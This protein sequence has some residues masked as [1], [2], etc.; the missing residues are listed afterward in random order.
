MTKVY[1]TDEQFEM[2]QKAHQRRLDAEINKLMQ[3]NESLR[4]SLE[5]NRTYTVQLQAQLLASQDRVYE[6]QALLLATREAA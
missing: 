5:Q 1:M 2:H 4:K 3:D 6:L